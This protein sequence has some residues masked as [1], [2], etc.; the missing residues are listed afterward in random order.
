MIIMIVIFKNEDG[1]Y[2][3]RPAFIGFIKN[4]I[5]RRSLCALLF[6]LM[7]LV[8]I[9]INIIQALFVSLILLVRSVY[10]PLSNIRTFRESEIWRRP[11]TKK[12]S[13]SKMN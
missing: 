11:R 5:A 8:T 6:P 10:Y 9:A 12:D 7:L 4:N 3:V 13:K 1:R 2:S